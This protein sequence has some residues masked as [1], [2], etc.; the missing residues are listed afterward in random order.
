M[1]KK[2]IK[3]GIY[4]VGAVDW[5]RRLFDALIPLPDGTSYNAYLVKGSKKT[6]LF[7]TVDPTKTDM[8]LSTLAGVDEIDYI[9]SHHAEQDHSGSIP[10]VLERYKN[11]KVV[12]SPKGRELLL[13]LLKIPADSIITAAD[14]E[15]LSLGDKTI[16]VIYTPWVHWPETF[17]TYIREDKVL[18]SCDLFG[19]HLSFS[20]IFVEDE[21]KACEAA[22]RYYAEV[23]MPFRNIIR[24]H[25]DRLEKYDIDIIAP[26][27]GPVHKNAEGIMKSHAKWISDDLANNAVIVYATMHGSTEAMVNHLTDA[28][29]QRGVNVERFNTSVMD[30]GKFAMSLVDAATLIFGSPTV[31]TG[32]HPNVISAAFLA[33]ALKPKVRFASIIG[34]QG[35]GGRVVDQIS[36]T[37]GTLKVEM[38]AP[39]LA[40]GMPKENDLKAL[41]NLAEEIA[42]RHKES[43]LL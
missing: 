23:M 13:D 29:S 17:S 15:T 6:A 3:E 24:K 12:T 39:V 4:W 33:N 40:K 38:L 43:K 21:E 11:A 9:I 22:K 34:S 26:S 19:S 27:H 16:E 25:L 42:K 1:E 10:Q 35:W 8:L 18:F 2:K 7:D 31:L 30:S 28:L 14:G 36:S 32:A 41:E 5:D 37:I 20:G